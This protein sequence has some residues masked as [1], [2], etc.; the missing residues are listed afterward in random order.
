MVPVSARIGDEVFDLKGANMPFVLRCRGDRCYQL[1]GES[2]VH[3]IMRGKREGEI[4]WI[5]IKLY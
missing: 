4:E 3:G 5:G 2:Y 1:I